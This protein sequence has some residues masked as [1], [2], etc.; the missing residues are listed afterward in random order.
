MM[1]D[2]ILLS[3]NRMALWNES[4]TRYQDWQIWKRIQARM[5]EMELAKREYLAKYKPQPWE[6]IQ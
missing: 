5:Y 4:K 3:F 6:Y 2:L 1:R